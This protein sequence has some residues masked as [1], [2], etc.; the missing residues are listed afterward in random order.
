MDA[1]TRTRIR[2]I[3]LSPRPH[4][5]L[6]TV[7]ELLEMSVEELKAEIKDGGI[8]AVSTAVGVRVTREGMVAAALG[9]WEA[10][11]RKKAVGA[12]G[13]VG[14]GLVRAI[15]SAKAGPF[16]AR[17]ITCEVNSGKARALAVLGAEVVAGNVD[18][19]ESLR[20]A[21]DGGYGAYC[22]TFFWNHFSPTT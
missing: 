6:N 18:D 8:V 4:F 12:A 10:A 1:N 20:R 11:G 7:A 19:A 3:F 17:A 5:P 16:V 21:F 9:G 2:H 13:P 14:G 15:T 22:V